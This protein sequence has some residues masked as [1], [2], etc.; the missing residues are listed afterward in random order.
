VQA[1]TEK[2]LAYERRRRQERTRNQQRA[3]RLLGQGMT[4]Q[5]VAAELGVTTR[6]LRNWKAAPAFQR[7]RERERHH[8]QTARQ[9]RAPPHSKLK[10]PTRRDAKEPLPTGPALEKLREVA[11]HVAALNGDPHPT[12][13]IAVPSTRKAANAVDSGAKVDTDQLSYLIILHGNFVGHVAHPPP[14]APLPQGSVGI[15][16]VRL[17]LAGRGRCGTRN[18]GGPGCALK[19][20]PGCEPWVANIYRRETL[21]LGV[22]R[23]GRQRSIAGGGEY[24]LGWRADAIDT[25][26]RPDES[27]EPMRAS[28]GLPLLGPVSVFRADWAEKRA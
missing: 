24:R 11:A 26:G 4:Q 27:V 23:R 19:A 3:A 13:A 9:R 18:P 25:G 1:R 5:A 22:Q 2:Q 21:N 12:K 6:T 16:A 28:A 17:S 20:R 8:K 15:A 10:P 7:E 14:G